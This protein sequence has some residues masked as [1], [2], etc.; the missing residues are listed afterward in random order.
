MMT[1]ISIL[2]LLLLSTT[3]LIAQEAPAETAAGLY[4]DGLAHLKAKEYS[5]AYE[6]LMKSIEI[7]NPDEDAQVLG[8]AKANGSIACYYLGNALL[9]EK[10]YDEALAKFQK[11]LELNPKS[12]TNQYGIASA[13]DKKG[14]VVKAVQ[15][16]LEAASLATAS[17][18]ADRAQRYIDRAGNK[19]GVTYGKEKYDEAIAAGEIFLADHES[20]DVSYYMAK[21]LLKKGQAADA[22]EHAAKAHALG[23]GED[24]GKYIMAYA[25]ALEAAGQT[26]EAIELYKKVPAGK[27]AQ[28]AKY[29]VETL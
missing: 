5:A 27:Y 15:H 17:G 11:G 13:T 3:Y 24:E 19:V 12:Y 10:K 2:F 18:K 25:E 28:T 4:N 16:Y 9:K 6:K 23:Q 21:A 1:R 26:S 22:I 7:A 8:L 29:K 20:A 14:M